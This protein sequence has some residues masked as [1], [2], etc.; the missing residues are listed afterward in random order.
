MKNE[1]KF[2]KDT[3]ATVILTD[4]SLRDYVTNI[5]SKSTG[6]DYDLIDNNLVLDSK[7]VNVSSKTKFSEVDAIYHNDDIIFNIEVNL[8]KSLSTEKK[9]FRYICNSILKQVP[10]G[11]KDKYKK[12]YQ[13]NINDYDILKKR[14]FIYQSS[15]MDEKYHEVRSDFIK[16][17]D[18]NMDYLRDKDY[19]EIK[20]AVGSLDYLLYIFICND[21][22]IREELYRSDKIMK[23]VN[24][25]LEE[26]NKDIEEVYLNPEEIHNEIVFE[27]GEKI[28]IEKGAKTKSLEIAK[29]LLNLGMNI[30]DI[31]NATGLTKE[32]IENL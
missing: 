10:P 15:I 13:I 20:E 18:I 32:E 4:E 16:I 29:N 8:W 5:I 1:H 24:K 30:E 3:V 23:K 7:L 28:G 26:L 31:L 12:V 14:D 17:I 21:E 2:L 6:I 27:E 22:N 11:S 25:R 19:N 9:N